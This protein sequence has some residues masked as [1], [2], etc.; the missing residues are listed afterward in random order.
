MEHITG[1]KNNVMELVAKNGGTWNVIT[2]VILISLMLAYFGMATWYSLQYGQY[3]STP[4]SIQ[5]LLAIQKQ[6]LAEEI[7]PLRQ[8]T[9][10]VCA[11]LISKTAPYNLIARNETPLVN[12]RPL[13]VRLTGYLGGING[14]RDG[15]FDMPSGVSWALSQGARAFV[16]DIDYLEDSPCQPRVIHRDSLGYMRSLHTG[17]IKEACTTLASQAFN[18]NYDPVLII[19]F[20]RKLPPGVNQRATFFQG[21]AASLDPLSTYHL[22]QNDQGNFHNCKSE[23]KIF[24]MPITNFQKNFIVLTNYDTTFVKSTTSNPK[25]NLHFWTHAR[26]YQDPNGINST[27]SSVTPKIPQGAVPPVKIG[28]TTQLMNIPEASRSNYITDTNGTA[29]VFTIA[30]SDVEDT[31]SNAQL[32]TLMN[33]LGIQCVPLDV[34]RLAARCKHASALNGVIPIR[35]LSDLSNSMNDEDPLSFWTYAGWSHK[36]IVVK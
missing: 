24:T 17:S 33:V 1:L 31:F 18:T 20:I 23:S 4:Q 26:I 16:F 9:A 6:N 7:E 5:K 15:V 25:D 11:Q 8:N 35:Q 32:H 30:M 10:S 14:P 21:I 29:S 27:I 36:L 34:V 3:R 28:A 22:G 2:I 13:T 12:W 19:L